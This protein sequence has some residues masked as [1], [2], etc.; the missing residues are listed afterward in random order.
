M[1]RIEPFLKEYRD[2]MELIRTLFLLEWISN[3]PLRQQVNQQDRI[4]QRF[5]EMAFFWRRGDRRE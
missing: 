1:A 5:R 2:R 3:L 4:V